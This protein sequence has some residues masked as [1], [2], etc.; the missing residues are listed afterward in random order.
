MSEA[1]KHIVRRWFE[2]VWN[3]GRAQTIDDL[4]DQDAVLHG[5]GDTMRGPGAF[6][7]FHAAYREALPDVQIRIEELIA[8]GDMVAVRW[9]A[10]GTHRGNSLG[11]AATQKRA[12]FGGMGI[13]RVRNGRIVEGWNNFDQLGMFRQLGV[14]TLPG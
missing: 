9:T 10:A 13:V 1:N 2:E 5:L 8:E 6:K 11:F 14:V 4:L 3:Q 12:E 7:P